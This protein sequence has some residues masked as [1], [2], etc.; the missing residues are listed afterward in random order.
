MG[1]NK[2]KPNWFFWTVYQ[3]ASKIIS[4]NKFHY[5]VNK[6]N[7][8]Y[9]RDK[10]KGAIVLYNHTC[11]ADHFISTAFFGK[12][13]AN[14]VVTRRFD[15][16]KPLHIA[17]K[18]VKAIVR[19]QFKA[20]MASILKIRKV[21]DNGGV[22]CI[23]PT[24]QVS[25]DGVQCHVH[26][27]MVKLLKM[28]KADVYTLRMEGTYLSYPKWSN[29]NR[30]YPVNVDCVKVFNGT[31]IKSL[32]DE[33]VYNK[34][35][36]SISIEDL[37]EQ[38]KKMIPLKGKEHSFGFNTVYYVCP[39]CLNKYTLINQDDIIKCSNCGNEI[40]YNQYGFLE[41]R[42]NNYLIPSNE[43]AWF[44][45]EE[46][47]IMKDIQRG[48]FFKESIVDFYLND[49][50]NTKLLKVGE[51]KLVYN[52]KELYYE[53]TKDGE[54]YRKDFD[55]STVYQFPFKP[56]VRFNIPDNEGMFEFVPHNKIEVT[57]WAQI[58]NSIYRIGV[59]NGQNNS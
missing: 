1:K 5:H 46:R 45:L 41:G 36:E 58:G 25:I 27:A 11:N 10:S 2:T 3:L 18:L 7:D 9:K 26:S 22:I 12:T 50:T 33:L 19:D 6:D 23:A 40:V 21:I 39:K 31:E 51:G 56:N 32:A 52:I 47:L 38:K 17:F 28:C 44:E 42:G 15:Y 53:G 16:E 34:I 49:E 14:Y 29:K 13:R 54:D 35:V 8:F 48:S 57:E 55:L 4:K 20:D 37:E 30:Y 59:E 43:H 24:G